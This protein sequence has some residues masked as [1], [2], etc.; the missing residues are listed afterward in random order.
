MNHSSFS[1]VIVLQEECLSIYEI[2]R[3]TINFYNKLSCFDKNYE[4]IRVVS[5]NEPLFERININDTNSIQ[6]LADEILHQNR[7]RI[8]EIDNEI[9][10]DTNYKLVQGFISFSLE[11]RIC[12]EPLLTLSFSFSLVKS[13][14]SRIGSIVV[15]EKCFESFTKARLFMESAVDS[16]PIKYSVLKI[17]DREINRVSR[18]FKAPLGWI[19]YFSKDFELPIPDDLE[20]VQFD[21][22]EKGKFL[23]ITRRDLQVGTDEFEQQKLK[24]LKVMNI[25]KEI[26]PGYAK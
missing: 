26:V 4:V 22:K 20:G 19:T 16:F 23:Y 21:Y 2:A 11:A 17:S 9:N 10:P 12:N 6:K 14:G 3:L 25:L 15:N 1:P 7:E 8:V 24:L 18:G 5:E 13:L